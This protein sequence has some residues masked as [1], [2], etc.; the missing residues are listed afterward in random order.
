MTRTSILDGTADVCLSITLDPHYG[1]CV[2]VYGDR[3]SILEV[4]ELALLA[5]MLAAHH[6]GGIRRSLFHAGIILGK[7]ER[8]ASPTMN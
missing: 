4:A 8:L 2:Y 1:I 7:V 6:V 3:I 5:Q